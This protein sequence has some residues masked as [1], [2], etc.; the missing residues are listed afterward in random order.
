VLR[1]FEI[2]S[3]PSGRTSDGV[4]A[5]ARACRRCGQHIPE[6]THSRVGWNL[7]DAP[8]QLVWEHAFASP[9]AYQ[10][11]MVHPY[12]AAVL[13]RYL[14]HD[15]PERV[16]T[17][18]VLGAGLVGYTHPDAAFAMTGGI[19]RLVL[20]RVDRQ[21]ASSDIDRMEEVLG[22][23]STAIDEMTVSVVGAN[24]LGPA[25]FD[26]VT[27]FTGRPRWTHLWEQGFV[28][29]DGL[30]AYRHG[31]SELATAER[32]WDR[33]LNGVIHDAVS[34]HYEIETEESQVLQE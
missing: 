5:L 24:T 27:P 26:G 33:F 34:L 23:A 12:H 21:A 16:V 3:V 28:D 30:D 17:D 25:W 15:S 22:Q 31:P 9:E 6:V 4:R 13:D 11:Y 8:V 2:Y 7:S 1:R 32:G 29:T 14:L 10:R 20:L 19:R 18:N